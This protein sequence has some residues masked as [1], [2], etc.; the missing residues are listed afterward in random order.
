[1]QR[2]YLSD[3]NDQNEVIKQL[4]PKLKALDC[5]SVGINNS[6]NLLTEALVK[7][8]RQITSLSFDAD[9]T[10]INQKSILNVRHLEIANPSTSPK[11]SSDLE[12][13]MLG[14]ARNINIVFDMIVNALSFSKYSKFEHL[15][16]FINEG[17]FGE[18]VSSLEIGLM[19]L[20][21]ISHKLLR[22]DINIQRL[23]TMPNETGFK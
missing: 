16:C 19:E 8:S 7:K 17:Q 18:I 9:R 14:T 21:F 6:A 3:Y 22:I 1:M 11:F 13:L 20:K 23:K 15:F 2:I 12:S 4:C 5:W 10:N